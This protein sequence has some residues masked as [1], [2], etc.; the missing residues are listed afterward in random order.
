[1]GKMNK[2]FLVAL[3]LAGGTVVGTGI[4]A[5]ITVLGIVTRIMD[6]SMTQRYVYV[7]KNIILL[8][9]LISCFLYMFEFNIMV[10]PSLLIIVGLFMGIFVGMIASAL[11]ETLDVFPFA[12]TYIGISRWIYLWIIVLILGKIVGS[13][14]Y[15]TVPGFY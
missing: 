12:S 10:S 6:L 15:W 11:A 13:L 4:S 7:Y 1:M 14:V 8:G 2:I 5:F 9:S 3:G